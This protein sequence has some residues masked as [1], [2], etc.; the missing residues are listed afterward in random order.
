MTTL[1]T[2][3]TPDPDIRAALDL[4]DKRRLV[5]AIHDPSFPG[6]AGEDL[7]RG[8]PYSRGGR[9]FLH[10]ARELG[11]DG[12]Q[13]GPQG[14]TTRDNPSPYDG[15]WF[16]RS[17]L[18]LDFF[19][20]A[21][22]PAYSGLL[23]LASLREQAAAT[24]GDGSRVAYAHAYEACENALADAHEQLARLRR[25][26]APEASAIDDA[27]AAFRAE[28]GDWL[29]ADA[30]H[31]ALV[32]DYGGVHHRDWPGEGGR[33]DAAL[34]SP[35]P[36]EGGAARRR[37]IAL[38]TR[39]QAPLERYALGQMLILAQHQALRAEL[40]TWG[41]RLYG[42]LQVGMSPCDDWQRASL[43]L[44]GYRMGAPPS[45]TN[46]AGQPWG[47]RVLDPAGFVAADGQPGPAMRFFLARAHKTLAEYD[48]V[49]IDHPHG[50]VCPWVYR[51]PQTISD[52]GPEAEA[53]A[54]HAVQTGAR[55]RCS[56]SLPDHPALAAYAIARPEQLAGPGTPRHAD[57]WVRSLEPGQVDQYAVLFDALLAAADARGASGDNLICEVL[58]TQPFPLAQVCE[59]HG[60]GRFRVTQKAKLERDDD[61]YRSENARPEDWI[62][63]GNHDTAPLW[64]L[65]EIWQE[66]GESGQQAAYLARRLGLGGDQA[67]AALAADARKLAHAKM[68]DV[69]ASEARHVQIFFADLLGMAET[70]NQPGT[71]GDHNWSLRVPADYA[72]AYP[73]AAARGEALD[74]SCVLA[75]ALR[76]RGASF[77]AEHAALIE[78]LERRV[79]WW[80][81][82]SARP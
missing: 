27:L 64:R 77:A 75:L 22:D 79:S 73:A 61:V 44:D 33:R 16:S 15:T 49:R 45:R 66:R 68:A 72:S 10:F 9:G 13:L 20:L 7:G 2:T 40:R 55:L 17:V 63:V 21:D 31:H 56:P 74:L 54:L 28:H 80:P 8:S 19:A 62:M 60:L 34:M 32:A 41:L 29:E 30:L 38:T 52:T 76:Q 18:S 67:A 14:Q 51:T 36:G 82:S 81:M 35:E 69:F 48:G 58:S 6:A 5:L 24:P 46:P 12:V 59:R 4:L 47:Y 39:L 42:D 26:R 25:E 11:F 53:A 3:P 70:Y 65:V 57:D 37:R 50:L 1:H 78:R 71:V 23:S 43:C